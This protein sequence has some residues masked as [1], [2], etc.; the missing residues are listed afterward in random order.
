MKEALAPWLERLAVAIHAIHGSRGLF[1][2]ASG[3]L[4]LSLAH[5]AIPRQFDRFWLVLP[6]FLILVVGLLTLPREGVAAQR[7]AERLIDAED[8]IKQ[9]WRRYVW[10]LLLLVL[11][12]PN[13]FLAAYGIPQFNPLAGVATPA[14]QRQVTLGVLFAILLLPALYLRSSRR[15]APDIPAMRPKDLPRDDGSSQARDLLLVTGVILLV[16]W[17]WLLKPF[18]S[19]FTLL[20]WPPGL[21][22]LRVGP[23]GVATIAFSLVIPMTLW[24]SLAAH[25]EL[26]RD[27]W[28]RNL[29]QAKAQIVAMASLHI[30]TILACVILHVYDLLWIAQ[31]RSAIGL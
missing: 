31:Y 16:V 4:V 20:D 23:R 30:V 8:A 1:Y 2:G 13:V 18:W 22:S 9:M 10:L 14:V 29:L 26:L 27:L 3:L 21:D 7:R 12:A 5:P 15:Y 11:L 25:F 19:P 24:M 28:E 6:F 17:A